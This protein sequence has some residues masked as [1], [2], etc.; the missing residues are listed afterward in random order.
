M[1]AIGPRTPANGPA[2]T[3]LVFI[4][5]ATGALIYLRVARSEA[6]ESDFAVLAA[7]LHKRG[8]PV[9][10]CADKHSVFRVNN[11]KA[12]SGHGITQFGRALR[13][14]DHRKSVRER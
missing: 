4:D 6:T 2:C 12:R 7:D 3:L 9:A 13:E 8:L 1:S 11:A 5:D 10:F 14:L